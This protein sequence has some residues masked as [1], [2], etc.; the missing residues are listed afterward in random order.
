VRRAY[1]NRCE[2]RLQEHTANCVDIL[3]DGGQ[4]IE[5]VIAT[6]IVFFMEAA[7]RNKINQYWLAANLF[8]SLQ[9][10]ETHTRNRQKG[11]Q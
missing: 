10:Q 3:V 2:K 6:R 9:T 4:Y 8:E 7:A 11:A 5:P 1:Q